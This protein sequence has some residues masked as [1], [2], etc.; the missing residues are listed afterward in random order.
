MLKSEIGTQIKKVDKVK[1]EYPCLFES[2]LGALVLISHR[3]TTHCIVLV[4]GG[5]V[6]KVGESV[7]ISYY[8]TLS[9]VVGEKVVTFNQ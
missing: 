5:D 4:N 2:K 3:L 6:K 8:T 9:P 7:A 1:V